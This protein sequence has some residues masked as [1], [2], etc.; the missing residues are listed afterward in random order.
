[1]HAAA[2][3]AASAPAAVDTR[4][5]G[6]STA[7]LWR[8]PVVAASASW[9]VFLVLAS[10]VLVYFTGH[11]G[12][13][14]NLSRTYQPPSAEHWMGTDLLGRDVL[15]RLLKGAQI[16]M[17]VGLIGATVSLVIGVTYG[18][19][20]AYVG[21]TVDNVMMR[22]VD[23]LYSLPRLIL[24]ILVITFF[25]GYAREW[26]GSFRKFG[27]DPSAVRLC[28]LFISLGCIEWL[29][30]AR[31]VRG[32]VLVLKEAQYVQAARALGQ[33][34]AAILW[35]HILPQLRGLILIYLTL[36]VPVIILEE[37]FLSF[38]GMGVQAPMASWGSLISESAKVINPIS[39]NWWLVVF[40]A[41]FL[42]LTLMSL[43]FIGDALR[44][45]WDPRSR[46]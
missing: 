17:L 36:N 21:G 13:A 5:A 12:T 16:S 35:L 39:I 25:D 29:T 22:V 28:L 41:V 7:F 8:D 18:A 37:S 4:G 6:S 31:I 3:N 45:A 30:M 9:L 23:I 15:T 10:F 1:M 46:K 14:N 43:N 27:L 42:A 11:D 40:P 32:Q 20:A 24:V 44:D 19:V 33:S 2:S 26:V 38:L 34:H